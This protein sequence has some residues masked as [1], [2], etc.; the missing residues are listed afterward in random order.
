MEVYKAETWEILRRYLKS[1]MNYS[2]CVAALDAA[3]AA[4]LP[5]MLPKNLEEVQSIV[6]ANNEILAE[7]QLQHRRYSS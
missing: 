2:A 3:L 4:A 1:E 5:R 7:L 6:I